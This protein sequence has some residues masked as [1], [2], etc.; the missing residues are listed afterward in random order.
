MSSQKTSIEKTL[1][2]IIGKVRDFKFYEL[3]M[4]LSLFLTILMPVAF[5]FVNLFTYLPSKEKIRSREGILYLFVS[6][7]YSSFSVYLIYN[8]IYLPNLKQL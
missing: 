4:A 3:F 1:D 2:S 5:A 6:L 7:V 8:N